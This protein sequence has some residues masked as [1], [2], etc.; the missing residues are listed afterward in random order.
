[1]NVRPCILHSDDPLQ[2]L[3]IIVPS[4]PFNDT[5]FHDRKNRSIKVPNKVI[6]L[7]VDMVNI[8]PTRKGFH[9]RPELGT[10]TNLNFLME[11]GVNTF[12]VPRPPPQCMLA[13]EKEMKTLE[14]EGDMQR[15][16]R[17]IVSMDDFYIKDESGFECEPEL[18]EVY[19]KQLVKIL[20]RRM[21]NTFAKFILVNV[22]NSLVAGLAEI[23][24]LA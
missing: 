8:K 24:G 4:M 18:G 19:R 10:D 3:G 13:T 11:A 12:P 20:A 22:V 1:M 21:D 2:S 23:T 15:S 5:S 16:D 14:M 6:G 9:F 7:I 17:R